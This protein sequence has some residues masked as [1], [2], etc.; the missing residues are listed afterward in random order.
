VRVPI[1][2]NNRLAAAS[3]ATPPLL[4]KLRGLVCPAGFHSHGVSI[5]SVIN[6]R[7]FIAGGTI[8]N[9]DISTFQAVIRAAQIGREFRA[10]A[11][12]SLRFSSWLRN[13]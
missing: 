10:I 6:H 11:L 2:N 12:S 7:A 9:S 3:P 4:S 13:G 1:Y 8:E 5:V